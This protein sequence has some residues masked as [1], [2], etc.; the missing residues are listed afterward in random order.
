MIGWL[1]AA[2]L[3]PE[4]GI[5]RGALSLDRS[6]TFS[7]L[8]WGQEGQG[9]TER[10]AAQ[11]RSHGMGGFADAAQKRSN[12]HRSMYAVYLYFEIAKKNQSFKILLAE[13]G[14]WDA[15][16]IRVTS[17]SRSK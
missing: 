5:G 2:V 11:T 16:L 12:T 14:I 7:R 4:A 3:R 1:F 15:N 13:F 17:Q 6:F 10:I 8:S 9:Q